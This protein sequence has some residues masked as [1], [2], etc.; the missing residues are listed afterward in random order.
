MT[1]KLCAGAKNGIGTQNNA[2]DEAS[3]R[4]C[5]GLFIEH[6]QTTM[7]SE[8]AL[9]VELQVL[10][11][12][13]EASTTGYQ[14]F[15]AL[16]LFLPVAGGGR[17]QDDNSS[18]R[19]E[20]ADALRSEVAALRDE[21]TALQ[22]R[23]SLG[24]QRHSQQGVRSPNGPGDLRRKSAETKSGRPSFLGSP[25]YASPARRTSK[26]ESGGAGLF[27]AAQPLLQQSADPTRRQCALRAVQEELKSGASAN[28][29]DGPD[30]PLRAAVQARSTELVSL[31]L[32]ARAD[33]E[34]E[35]PKGVRLLHLAAFKGQDEICRL[36]LA[37]RASP[38]AADCHGQ[39]PLFF[40]PTRPICA[41]LQR[42]HANVNVINRQGQSALHLAAKAGLGDVLAWMAC[43]VTH[44]LLSLRDAEGHLAGDYARQAGIKPEVLEKLSLPA[45][46]SGSL[47]SGTFQPTYA[48]LQLPA[49]KVA[50][51]A[52]GV[53]GPD[54][55]ATPVLSEDAS[56]A[57][58]S[59]PAAWE[60]AASE[61]VP[62]AATETVEAPEPL[63]E[64]LAPASLDPG[65]VESFGEMPAAQP[66]EPPEE[67]SQFLEE[68]EEAF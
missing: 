15:S 35:D 28:T 29:W 16:S 24:A 27:K 66:A 57:E 12:I 67:R 53:L 8:I 22:G 33:P 42:S 46:A 34:E 39:T 31:L 36:L 64:A 10:L 5:E 60:V 51:S 2:C 47:R 68:L 38:N 37:S 4:Y 26:A 9:L 55:E 25:A 41:T 1:Y 30:T 13:A 56:G 58:P 49:S 40:A 23:A 54:P 11:S 45:K 48:G 43:N 63:E 32:R 52:T 21:L 19:F 50:K 6:A 61:D 65:V 14:T 18:T 44:A 20:E 7:T 17:L 3:T 62:A 59:V